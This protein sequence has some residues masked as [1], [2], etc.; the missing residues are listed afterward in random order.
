MKDDIH[1]TDPEAAPLPEGATS[2][3]DIVLDVQPEQAPEA[4]T[5]QAATAEKYDRLPTRVLDQPDRQ[6]TH[7]RRR[8]AH[9]PSL[10]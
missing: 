10:L 6:A 2:T 1:H 8:T 7:L 9:L 3:V 4:G 5:E